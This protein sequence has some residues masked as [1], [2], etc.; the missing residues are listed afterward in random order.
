MDEKLPVT[1]VFLDTSI[2]VSTNFNFAGPVFLALRSRIEQ[3]Q[4]RLGI[5][6]LMIQEVE[7][8]I[9]ESLAVSEQVLQKARPKARI[10]RNSENHALQG[11]FADWDREHEGRELTER[12][13]KFL[14][15]FDADIVEHYDV[16]AARIFEL[17]FSKKPPFGQ[18]KKK[19]EF[20]D[21][22]A[23]QYLED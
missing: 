4:A 12:F 20:P 16:D 2:Y 8:Q 11:L 23:L 9:A 6:R 1:L 5:T 10:L 13:L 22:F 14:D 18:G 3:G 15:E 7:A 17:Y 21:A 19:N